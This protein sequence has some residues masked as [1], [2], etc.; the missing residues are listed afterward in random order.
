MEEFLRFLRSLDFCPRCV[1][2]VGA[3]E[4]HW[5]VMAAEIFPD[6]RMVLI[7]P[8][9]EMVPGLIAFT[10]AHPSARFVQAGA[11]A[12]PGE[13]I[14]T[15]T[16]DLSGSSFIPRPDEELQQAGRQRLTPIVTIDA[17]FAEEPQLPDLVKLDIQGYE[18]EAL[19]GAERLF[20]YTECFILEVSLFGGGWTRWPGFYDVV[21]FMHRRGY[22]VYD[23]CGFLRR[24]LDDALGQVDLAFVRSDGCLGRDR[25]WSLADPLPPEQT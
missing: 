11:G 20:G 10:S 3:N 1:L 13:A 25:R 5:A 22:Q 6:A 14:Q 12:Q 21:D 23:V 4:T 7:E 2:D 8:Q 24:Q 17:V 16:D 18:L 15:I 9:E 19:K